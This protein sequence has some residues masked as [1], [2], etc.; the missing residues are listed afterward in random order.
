MRRWRLSAR[1]ERMLHV[2]KAEIE[3]RP[4]I[5]RADG[6]VTEKTVDGAF[7]TDSGRVQRADRGIASIRA[8]KAC[9]R[10]ATG[11]VVHDRHVNRRQ[12]H[13]VGPKSEQSGAAA[14]DFACRLQPSLRGDG[15]A[16]P[17]PM[18]LGTLAPS[19]DIEDRRHR[20]IRAVRRRSETTPPGPAAYRRRRRRR[21]RDARTSARRR[22]APWRSARAARRR[23]CR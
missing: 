8:G 19:D 11:R 7:E 13:P 1:A 6:D 16:R 14:G 9:D 2:P 22:P 12:R 15:E 4:Q 10:D 23:R 17:R 5:R 21:W 18:V 3:P 20:I